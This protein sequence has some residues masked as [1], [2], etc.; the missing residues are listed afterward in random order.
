MVAA[1]MAVAILNFAAVF[2]AVVT[3]P[4]LADGSGKDAIANATIDCCFHQ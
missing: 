3:I 1:A 4:S 2:D